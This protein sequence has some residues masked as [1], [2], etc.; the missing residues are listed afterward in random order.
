M[1]MLKKMTV[2]LVALIMLISLCTVSGVYAETALAPLPKDDSVTRI[3]VFS[4]SHIGNENGSKKME[5][6]LKTFSA[7]DPDYDGLVMTGDIALQYG[8]VADDYAVDSAPYDIIL[9]DL[10]TLAANKPYSWAM[11]NHEF[12]GACVLAVSQSEAQTALMEKAIETS[13]KY[14]VEKTGM[15]LHDDVVIGGYHFISAAPIDYSNCYD[16]AAENYIMSR[17]DAAIEADG[18]EKPIFI[19]AHHAPWYTTIS[20][21]ETVYNM[22]YSATLT[23]YLENHPNVIVLTGHTHHSEYDPRTIW[24]GGYTVVNVG[25]TSNSSGASVTGETVYYSKANAQEAIMIEISEDNVVTFKKIDVY[26]QCYI[27]EDWVL[28]IP[29]MVNNP[30]NTNYWKYTDARYNN[31]PTPYFNEGQSVVAVDLATTSARV[32]FNQAM[33]DSYMGDDI[34]R[35]YN[36]KVVNKK[37]QTLVQDYNIAADFYTSPSTRVN[38]FDF[39]IDELHEGTEYK[40]EITAVSPY[41]KTSKPI[42]GVFKT[43]QKPSSGGSGGGGVISAPKSP[44]EDSRNPI[45][46]Y[47]ASV[48][49]DENAPAWH[50]DE[51]VHYVTNYKETNSANFGRRLFRDGRGAGDGFAFTFFEN[52][53]YITFEFDVLKDGIYDLMAITDTAAENQTMNVLIDGKQVDT[54]TAP[55]NGVWYNC[56]TDYTSVGKYTLR[57]GTH[58]ITMQ[59]ASQLNDELH[60]WGLALAL[61][62]EISLIE[63]GVKESTNLIHGNNCTMYDA[64][65]LIYNNVS[66]NFSVDVPTDGAYDVYAEL[67]TDSAKEHTFTV[68][69]D[70]TEMFSETI[71]TTAGPDGLKTFK[72]KEQLPLNAGTHTITFRTEEWKDNYAFLGMSG[73]KL[74]REGSA[75][76]WSWKRIN[77]GKDNEA[78]LKEVD[79]TNGTTYP[80][81]FGMGNGC[82]FTASVTPSKTGVYEISY[83]CAAVSS[84]MQTYLNNEL[85]DATTFDT[86]GSAAINNLTWTTPIKAVLLEGYTYDIKMLKQGGGD[87]TLKTLDVKFKEELQDGNGISYDLFAGEYSDTNVEESTEESLWPRWGDGRGNAGYSMYGTRYIS[88][89]I[90][91][92]YTGWYD[93]SVLAYSPT[94]VQNPASISMYVDGVL[95]N[96]IEK[97]EQGDSKLSND[98]GEIFLLEGN[99]TVKILNNGGDMDYFKTRLSYNRADDGKAD[100]TFV[101]DCVDYSDKGGNNVQIYTS[102]YNGM[103]LAEGNSYAEYIVDV[104]AGNY[105]FEICYGA[106]NWDANMSITLNGGMLGV[107]SLPQNG[108]FIHKAS[109]DQNAYFTPEILSLEN[110]RNTIKL[111]CENGKYFSFTTFRL[112]R[113]SEPISQLYNSEYIVPGNQSGKIVAGVNTLRVY[114]PTYMK[115]ESVEMFACIYENGRLYM[116]ATDEVNNASVNEVLVATFKDVSLKS[117]NEYTIKAFFWDSA[118]GMIPLCEEINFVA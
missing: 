79:M 67:S 113:V 61:E 89:D 115:D 75:S 31:A 71:M 1:K 52:S 92:G 54:F 98:M 27:G 47:V 21:T 2:W 94:T 17:I 37:L 16:E 25:Y 28:D 81:S 13:K 78:S 22:P 32:R 3:G 41:G 9:N 4:D 57:A 74:V 102:P 107:Y 70:G 43:L 34:I 5:E 103:V 40:V 55:A 29:A 96:T 114:L 33:I 58:T 93:V 68:L 36:V 99:H 82:Y 65:T 84:V 69:V 6:T 76:D 24:Q 62:D 8:T 100:V 10:N 18:N 44:E 23:N 87:A 64:V 30:G 7:I 106:E 118:E 15:S 97:V 73:F 85:I 63:L 50:E 72:L 60:F 91:V 35:Y 77:L 80:D 38:P 86:N 101:Y 104:P 108:A 111:R 26:N 19:S 112:K 83:N 110:G 95:K 11:G 39:T 105:V 66:A 117:G 53:Q 116:T 12:P 88:Y 20:S 42:S 56:G 49:D 45:V 46:K 51:N 59:N 109:Y 48:T 90:E 14:Y